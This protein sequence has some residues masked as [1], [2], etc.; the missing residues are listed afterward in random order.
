M[1]TQ[2]IR[3][4]DQPHRFRRKM[5]DKVIV[6]G[7]DGYADPDYAGV[8]VDGTWQGDPASSGG[9]YTESYRI[10]RDKDGYFDAA[11]HTLL[12]R[13]DTDY[14]LRDEIREKIR[15]YALPR[16]M[17]P[18]PSGARE[19]NETMRSPQGGAACSACG[20]KIRLRE[21]GAM[22]FEYSSGVYRFHERCNRIW[23]GEVRQRRLAP[24]SRS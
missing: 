17:P 12:K 22:E 13:F 1:T 19:G 3:L 24:P 2:T 4:A 10:K 16:L 8:I 5:G 15:T 14:E 23:L 20:H 18:A 6:Q 7:S 11:E 9:S 21:L